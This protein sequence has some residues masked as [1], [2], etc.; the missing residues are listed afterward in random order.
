MMKQRKSE[1]S[2]L[3]AGCI[4]MRIAAV[5]FC[6]VV[7]STYL[8]AGLFARYTTNGSSGDSARVAGFHVALTGVTDGV[9]YDVTTLEPG[10]VTVTL[11]NQSEVAV[12][13][14]IRVFTGTPDGGVKVTWE[15]VDEVLWEDAE[16]RFTKERYMGPGA[17]DTCTL[18]F[19]AADWSQITQ[20][21]KG[22]SASDIMRTFTVYVDVV[23][24][25]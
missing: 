17:S 12:S 13:Y 16:K 6:L 24:V 2:A 22:A 21:V 14:K 23:Q 8:M 9:T 3:S 15:E 1:K 10:K 11:D 18:A 5:L 19:T 7:V 4:L 25:D 20:N